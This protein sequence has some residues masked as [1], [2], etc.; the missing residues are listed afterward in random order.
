[1]LQAQQDVLGFA[2]GLSMRVEVPVYWLLLCRQPLK[3]NPA[4]Y[5]V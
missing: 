5:A 4:L 2:E 3:E 1:M